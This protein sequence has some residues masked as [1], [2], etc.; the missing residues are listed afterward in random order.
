M[1]RSWDD[2]ERRVTLYWEVINEKARNWEGREGYV[3][4]NILA[5]ENENA[6]QSRERC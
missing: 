2:V 6:V 5:V 4:N 1:L 3:F